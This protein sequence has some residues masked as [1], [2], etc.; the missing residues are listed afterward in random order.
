MSRSYK[1]HPEFRNY[2]CYFSNKKSRTRANRK[3]RHRNRQII[4]TIGKEKIL[5]PDYQD[6]IDYR[7]WD[8]H[9]EYTCQIEWDW[10]YA[11]G[12]LCNADFHTLREVSDVWCFDSDGLAV[13]YG[14]PD[15]REENRLQGGFADKED[16]MER[17][18]DRSLVDNNNPMG[19]K[20]MEFN[21]YWAKYVYYRYKMK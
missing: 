1:K 4:R 8:E 7:I 6:I 11:V 10:E 2:V 16:F 15:W 18:R 3:L 19:G 5:M 13:Y 20:G 21:N 12:E 9:P 17:V 14:V